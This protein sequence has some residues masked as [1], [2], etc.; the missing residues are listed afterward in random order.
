MSIS[1]SVPV[2]SRS[3]VVG[4]TLTTGDFGTTSPNLPQRLLIIGEANEANQSGLNTDLVQITS[5]AQAGEL[6]GY[7]SP[8]HLAVR[9]LKPTNGIG[10]GGIPIFVGAQAKAGGATQ[11][12]D[13]I[14]VTGTATANATHTVRVCGRENVDGDAYS[15]VVATGDTPTDIATK[16]NDA[17][18]SVLRAPIT[19]S[20]ALG[21]VTCTSKWAGITADD[22]VI[23]VNNNGV[24]AG[25]S[26]A[27]ANDTNGAGV[28]A[29]TST[30]NKIGSEWFTAV[31]NCYGTQTAVMDEL[32]T[33]NGKPSPTSPTGR[34]VGT[35]MKPFVAFTGSVADDPTSITDARKDELT[36]AICPAPNSKGLPLEAG[37]NMAR[38]QLRQAQDNPHLDVSGSIYPDMPFPLDGDIGSMATYT[39]RDLFLKKGCSTV[40][41]FDGNYK[42]T[43]FATTYHPT[44]EE[45]PQFRYVRSLVQDF[46]IKY[47][48]FLLEQLY[49]VDKAIAGDD[50]ITSATN[51]IKPKI[52]S[53]IVFELAND[54]ADRAII[55]D[56]PFMQESINVQLSGTNPDR[57]ETTFN[58]KRSGFS[59]I[60]STTAKAGFSFGA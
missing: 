43:D 33:F 53:G 47:A 18:N 41:A 39:N 13:E 14:T 50:S 24:D 8:I 17:I 59:R 21:V 37:A 60:A 26:Y 9:I 4:Y 16:I 35:I 27:V 52:W 23:E 20:S 55:D 10:L 40:E 3:K 46:N 15:F 19:S 32:E 49:V 54:L 29:V 56:A 25:V 34:F 48:Y 45:P 30:L 42:V 38:L 36:I 7:G 57:L 58:Y 31:L 22:I 2:E 12:V 1:N 28:P 5:E 6:Y 51:V 44:G 11:R